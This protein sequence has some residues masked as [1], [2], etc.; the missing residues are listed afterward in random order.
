MVVSRPVSIG[1][2][3]HLVFLGRPGGPGLVRCS[4]PRRAVVANHGELFVAVLADGPFWLA[5]PVA[6]I[7]YARS[8]H[9]LD[10]QEDAM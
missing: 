9:Q 1:D 4:F 3:R 6:V 5:E 2:R 10:T 7:G 8:G